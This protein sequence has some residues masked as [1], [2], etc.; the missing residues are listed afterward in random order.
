MADTYASFAD[1]AAHEKLGVDYLISARTV[2]DTAGAHIAIHGGRIEPAT[3]QLADYCAA[4]SS[5]S[6]FSFQGIKSD[7][8]STLH[9]TS[10]RFAHP[11]LFEILAN[12]DWAVSWHGTAGSDQVTYLGGSDLE[13]MAAIS[14]R[15]TAA[16]FSV[17]ES[18]TE[19]DGND[20]LNVV[21][22]TRRRAG[23]QLELSRGLRES[24]YVG[25][26]ITGAALA[27]PA[28]RTDAFFAYAQAVLSAIA[29][30]RPASTATG[31]RPPA[32]G[33]QLASSTAGYP[34]VGS[35]QLRMPF[36]LDAMGRVAVTTAPDQM[37]I[38][39][40]RGVIGT[41]PGE[42]IGVP[43]FGSDISQS[44][45]RPNDPIASLIITEAVKSAMS[46]W[47]PAAVITSINPVVHDDQEG[48]VDVEVQVAESATPGVEVIQS[49]TVS[50]LPGGLVIGGSL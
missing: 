44:L 18:P 21:N 34:G 2:R 20:V 19:I 17:A 10:T 25:G 48:I 29:T 26:D 39:R 7:N 36:Q 41:T 8:N 33:A 6:Y 50:I 46:R 3:T 24:F 47:E 42:Y 30:T 16:G 43:A 15:L 1:L 23:V 14:A 5:A 28:N 40:A 45:F 32:A 35:L 4:E 9:V 37:L 12:S 31:D 22:R 13:L 11:A 38:Q 49:E 27:N